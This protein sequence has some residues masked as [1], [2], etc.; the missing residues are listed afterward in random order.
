LK[1]KQLNSTLLTSIYLTVA[2]LV[3]SSG[4]VLWISQNESKL[5]TLSAFEWW[6]VTFFC[7]LTSIFALTPPTF[8]ALVFGYFLGWK[9][10]FYLI[11]LNI[12]AI[13]LV[14]YVAKFIDGKRFTMLLEKNPKA[15]TLLENI[16]KEEFKIILWAKLSPALPFA[17]TNF[18]FA[19]SNAQLKNIILG[20]VLGMIPRTVIAVWAGQQASEI[21]TLLENP[22]QGTNTKWLIAGLFVVSMV[23]LVVALRRAIR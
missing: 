2:P 19:I 22:N 8:L 18:L 7:V 4:V 23:G 21:R 16:R 1:I 15:K 12:L 11:V 3:V 20:G 13:F 6:G 14:N 10:I 9:A 5:A 17:L